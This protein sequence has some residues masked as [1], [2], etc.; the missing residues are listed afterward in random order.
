MLLHL[1]SLK[2]YDNVTWDTLFRA[3]LTMGFGEGFVSFGQTFLLIVSFFVCLNGGQ[4]KVFQNRRGARQ[5]CPLAP[6]RFLDRGEALNRFLHVEV[7]LG[8]I[9]EVKLPRGNEQH[10]VAQYADDTTLSFLGRHISLEDSS[11]ARIFP[12]C[13]RDGN[14]LVQIEG[15]VGRKNLK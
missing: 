8:R 6:Y 12:P 2:G 9:R 14:Q 11:S 4:T 1:D 10:L 5:G 3:I 13:F 7:T 15:F